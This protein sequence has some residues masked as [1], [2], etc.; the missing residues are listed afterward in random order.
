MTPTFSVNSTTAIIFG[1]GAIGDMASVLKTHAIARP[2]VVM[3]GNLAA[4]DHCRRMLADLH[5]Q[6]FSVKVWERDA[7]EPT[8][9]SVVPGI[10]AYHTGNCDGLL[11]YGGG[12]TLDAAKAVGVL[13]HGGGCDPTPYGSHGSRAITGCA[14]VIAIP[15]T[16]GTGSEVTSMAL[17][18]E[19]AGSRK[20]LLRHASL[21]P[22]AAIIDP[23][24]MASQ[25][26]DVMLSGAMDALSHTV[27]CFTK[28]RDHPYA[29]GL[30][31]TALERIVCHLPRAMA[32]NDDSLTHLAAAACLAGLAFDVGGL[33]FHALSHVMGVRYCLPHGICC[34][35]VLRAGLDHLLPRVPDKL[36][37]L[38]PIVAPDV[39]AAGSDHAAAA[40]VDGIIGFIDRMKVPYPRQICD[41]ENAVI[42]DLVQETEANGIRNMEAPALSALW[43]TLIQGDS[44]R[45]IRPIL[46]TN[47]FQPEIT[48]SEPLNPT[49]MK[50]PHG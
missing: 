3:D 48:V 49:E 11:G 19:S 31:L 36:A 47:R 27:E 46:A 43:A 37:R 30:A 5:K 29:D 13:A 7:T 15:T 44:S 50:S 38:A 45:F 26:A 10:G 4:T 21:R 20:L 34:A 25:P 9:A 24:L 35:M 8:V 12:S 18:S 14:P 41:I 1:P 2:L 32:E 33:Q 17:L 28:D 42:N 23:L 39:A 22:R 40:V 16:C 6:G